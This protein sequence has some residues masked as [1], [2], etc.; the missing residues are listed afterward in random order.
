MTPT[1]ETPLQEIL[2]LELD[3]Y[4]DVLQ[5]ISSQASKEFA[6]EKVRK[7]VERNFHFPRCLDSNQFDSSKTEL[8]TCLQ[9]LNCFKTREKIYGTVNDDDDDNDDFFPPGLGEDEE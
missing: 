9:F 6:L 3:K 7:T 5:E 4:L 8:R 2:K 1:D